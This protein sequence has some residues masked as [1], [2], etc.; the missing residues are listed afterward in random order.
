MYETQ[1]L[2]ES[3]QLIMEQSKVEAVVLDEAFVVQ[4]LLPTTVVNL[5]SISTQLR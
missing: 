5:K 1:L 4:T 2:D 3:S